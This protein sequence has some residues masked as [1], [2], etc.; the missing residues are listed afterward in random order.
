MEKRK[1]ESLPIINLE[2]EEFSHVDNLNEI[3]LR[4]Y[5]DLHIPSSEIISWL[6]KGYA[7]HKEGD[8]CKFCGN[9]IN[10]SEIK[11]K[12][13]SY[14]SNVKQRDKQTLLKYLAEIKII[15]EQLKNYIA[16]EDIFVELISPS[17][18]KQFKVLKENLIKFKE[19]NSILNSKIDKIEDNILCDF[20]DMSKL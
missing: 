12:L 4:V 13:D 18:R 3:F 14:N 7:L 2:Y 15:I 20:D 8:K 17:V 16:K 11:N 10:L 1:I 9:V 19:I 5:D 6:N